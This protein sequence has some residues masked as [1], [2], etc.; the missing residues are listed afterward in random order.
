MSHEECFVSGPNV[1]YSYLGG[2]G[3]VV[4]VKNVL[5]VKSIGFARFFF[6]GFASLNYLVCQR[7]QPRVQAEAPG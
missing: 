1:A 5:H 6:I 3:A 2:G 4:R 7:S